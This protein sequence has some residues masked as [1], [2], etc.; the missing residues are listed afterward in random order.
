MRKSILILIIK[1]LF[2]NI[3][4]F[5][6]S[7]NEPICIGERFSIHSETLNQERDIY[8]RL[9]KGY[10]TSNTS[11]PVHFI[12]DAEVTYHSYTGLVEIMYEGEE[13]PDP[14]IVGIPNVDRNFDFNP[15]ENGYK[16]LDFITRELVS[17]I[18]DKY[19]AD[20]DRLLCGYSM[21][22][23]YVIFVLMNAP[24]AF[25]SYLSGSPYRLDIF[26]DNDIYDLSSKV[27]KTKTLY[28]SMGENDRKEQI[29]FFLTF[30][31]RLD[32]ANIDN[33]RFKYVVIPNRNHENGFIINWIDGLA[34]IS[35][36]LNR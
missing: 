7:A 4:L 2:P 19:R 33:I 24:D 34:Y 1:F 3:L 5:G 28:T 31:K 18:E 9:P 10:D 6:Q 25:S 27:Q 12:L 30:C 17:Y 16:F 26:S 14:I 36:I 29:Q 22:G 32:T 23:T 35:N 20:G 21:G 11:Y 8:I 15:K 13:I